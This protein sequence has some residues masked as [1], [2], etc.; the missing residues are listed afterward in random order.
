MKN[1]ISK[2]SAAFPRIFSLIA[3]VLF[4]NA[5]FAQTVN[6]N[7]GWEFTKNG[8]TQTINLPHTWNKEDVLDDEP[9]Y[10]RGVAWYKKRFRIGNEYN[11]KEISFYFEGV[12]QEADIFINGKKAGHHT[13]GYTGFSIP[14]TSLVKLNANNEI[15]VKVDNSYNKNIP[16]LTADFSFFGGMYRDV[17]LI[18]TNKIHISKDDF[19]SNGVYITTPFVSAE[20]AEATIKTLVANNTKNTARVVLVSTLADHRGKKLAESRSALT[21]TANS[22]ENVGLQTIPVSHPTL[23]SPENPYLYKLV[24]SIFDQ[25]GKLL[26]VVRQPVGFRWFAFDA[27]KGF[28]LNGKPCKLIGVSRHQDHKGLGN[29]VPDS[30]AVNDVVLLKKMGANF[31]RIAHYPQDPCVV[32]ACDSLGILASMEIPIVNEITASDSF[33]RNCEGMLKEMIRQ[34]FNHPS[35]IMW[36]Y[37]NE[38]LLRTPFAGDQERRKT[39]YAEVAALAHQLEKLTR[40]EDPYRSTMMAYHG[41]L[42]Q[43]QTAGLLDIPMVVGWNL[44]SGWYGGKLTDFPVF[45]DEFHKNFPGKPFMVTEYGSDAD[46]RIR[47]AQPVRFDKSIEYTTRFHQFYFKEIM[48]RPFVAG[49]VI[50]N[51]ADFNSETRTETMPHMNNKG[52]LEWDRKPK[53]PYYFYEAVLAKKPF[54]K[55]LGCS[56]DSFDTANICYQTIRVAS[57]LDSV[58]IRL[59]DAY[60]STIPIT[61]GLGELKVGFNQVNNSIVAEGIRHN[62][63]VSDRVT[64]Q[65]GWQS[66]CVTNRSFRQIN[67][68]LGTTRYYLDQHG[69][70]WQ[71]SQYYQ[72]GSWGSMG[73]KTFTID[74]LPYGTDKNIRGTDDDPLYQ[75]QQTG[76]EHYRLDVP[77]GK[78]AITL[79]FAELLGEPV[80]PLP[81]NLNDKDRIDTMKKRIFNVQ[82]NG[83]MLLDHFN[84][85]QEYGLARAVSRSTTVAVNND[86]GVYIDFI[87][88]EGEPVLNALELKR[89]DRETEK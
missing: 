47:S 43:Y 46:P 44:Y 28:L 6:M 61:D 38:V 72:K 33:Y 63:L 55:I 16:P 30:I 66:P 23:W 57:N 56:P 74:R 89:M 50:W 29:A 68:L 37:M 53:D 39:Y 41:N 70:W 59:N 83:R 25:N 60:R 32:K 8:S 58:T 71:P 45:L 80:Q 73:G 81:Y 54:L 88:V 67:I 18:A 22:S 69:K 51:L 19:G 27:N 7:K 35:V 3:C 13:G 31:L 34:N 4:L 2:R 15:L 11:G 9:G 10:Y 82:V 65:I 86:E 85:A 77:P 48:K 84:I 76:I 78:Y 20:K 24:T 79:H 14:I 64:T 49:S 40:D 52:L 62:S 17:F 5:L 1:K 26:D 21:L 75:T 36:C 12:N 87:P 42:N